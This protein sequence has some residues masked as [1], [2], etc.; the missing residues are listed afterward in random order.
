MVKYRKSGWKDIENQPLHRWLIWLDQNSPA[1]LLKEVV[2]MDDAIQKADERMV[3]VTGDK[4]AIRAYEMR[5]MGKSD[6]ES[7]K[8]D[9]RREGLE[10]GRKEGLEQGLQEGLKEGLEQGLQ[11]GLKEG[12]K[13]GFEMTARNALAKGIPVETISDITGLSIEVIKNLEPLQE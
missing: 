12:L 13:E 11:E 1:E 3:Y 10:E 5:M 9:G 2:N 4:E 8:N 6:W 7:Y